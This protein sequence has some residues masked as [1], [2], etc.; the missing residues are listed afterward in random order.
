M[1]DAG[2]IDEKTMRAYVYAPSNLL[3]FY[4]AELEVGELHDLQK[5]VAEL[6]ERVADDAPR[7][8]S[9]RSA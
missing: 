6:E 2:D 1:F 5:Q 8:R 4:K 3:P 7:P 9:R